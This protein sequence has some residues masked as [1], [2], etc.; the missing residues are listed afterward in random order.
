VRWNL[1][2]DLI[3]IFFM[4]RDVVHFVMCFFGHLEFFLWETL[5]QFICPSLYYVIDF[6][7]EGLVF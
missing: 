6:G 7:G 1:N 2:M 4:V 5:G 3:C